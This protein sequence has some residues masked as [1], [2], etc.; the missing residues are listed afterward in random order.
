MLWL[1]VIYN[2][3]ENLIWVM[4]NSQKFISKAVIY[5]LLSWLLGFFGK[6]LNISSA[7]NQHKIKTF[8]SNGEQFKESEILPNK[9]FISLKAL[10]LSVFVSGISTPQQCQK[11]QTHCKEEKKI[12]LMKN[13][14]QT[15]FLKKAL[16]TNYSVWE[17]DQYFPLPCSTARISLGICFFFKHPLAFR[18][19]GSLNMG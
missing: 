17:S 1:W 2:T 6:C 9:S 13:E 18:C 8:N 19:C 5:R 15:Q 14:E 3:L 12:H 16:M 10:S 7:S 11:S 4:S